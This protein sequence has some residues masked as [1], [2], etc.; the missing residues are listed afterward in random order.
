MKLGLNTFSL[1]SA[2][3]DT[4]AMVVFCFVTGMVIEIMVSGMS[5]EQSLASRIVSIPV[6]IVIAWPYGCYRNQIIAMGR[7]V[8][9]TRS[10]KLISDLFAYVSFQSPVYVGILIFVGASSEQIFTSV[11]TNAAISCVM[12]IIYGYFLDVCRRWFRV[13]GYS[14][15]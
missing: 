10:S 5:F 1:R 3:A 7:K 12:G 9:N 6:N 14:L 11:L 15:A 8:A 13:P 2:A 4:F